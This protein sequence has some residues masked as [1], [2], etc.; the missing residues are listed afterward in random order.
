VTT[1]LEITDQVETRLKLVAPKVMIL[2]GQVPAELPADEAKN[3][4]PY[5]VIWDGIGMGDDD[6][7]DLS[8]GTDGSSIYE[9]HVTIASGKLRWTMEAAAAVRRGL[10]HWQP[11]GNVERLRD[12]QT[13]APVDL[14]TEVLPNRHYVPVVFRAAY[15]E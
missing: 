11:T 9:V 15:K 5:A 3:V 2:R 8:G 4:F 14:D 7:E 13:W 1:A 6:A 10:D 12:N